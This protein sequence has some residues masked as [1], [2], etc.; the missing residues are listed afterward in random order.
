MTQQIA[1]RFLHPSELCL[2]CTLLRFF[3]DVGFQSL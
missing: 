3:S 2:E 1:I